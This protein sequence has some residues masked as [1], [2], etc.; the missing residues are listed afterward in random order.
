MVMVMPVVGRLC[1]AAAGPE[2][3]LDL[4]ETGQQPTRTLGQMEAVVAVLAVVGIYQVAGSPPMAGVVVEWVFTV[5]G[6]MEAHRLEVEVGVL[7]E[8]H[9]VHP[10]QMVAPM[11][12][13]V[14]TETAP[15]A[16][17]LAEQSESSGRE[18]LGHSHRRIL[19]ICDVVSA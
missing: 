15:P 14:L 13:V 4:V 5:R 11:V 19:E 6:R 9:Q 7:L 12:E 2:D 18:P 17:V 3:T 8:V 10:V 16:Q 1:V